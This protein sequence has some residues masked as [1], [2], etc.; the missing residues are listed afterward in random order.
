MCMQSRSLK[1]DNTVM[2][3]RFYYIDEYIIHWI[4]IICLCLHGQTH[5]CHCMFNM[6]WYDLCMYIVCSYAWST[7]KCS[8]LSGVCQFTQLPLKAT[9][10]GLEEDTDGRGSLNRGRCIYSVNYLVCAVCSIQYNHGIKITNPY[11][12]AI[13]L[14]PLLEFSPIFIL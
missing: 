8:H 10:V 5:G 6:V 7:L 14:F 1:I 11:G 2:T 12:T 4:Y 13:L 3:V 9:K